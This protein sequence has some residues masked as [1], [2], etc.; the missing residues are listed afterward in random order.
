[1]RRLAQQNNC[2]CD[3]QEEPWGAFR[4]ETFKPIKL[5]YRIAGTGFQSKAKRSVLFFAVEVNFVVT[6]LALLYYQ[7]SGC[8]MLKVKMTIVL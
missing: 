5:R 4:V 1:M 3:C 2:S 6:A 7:G 8:L